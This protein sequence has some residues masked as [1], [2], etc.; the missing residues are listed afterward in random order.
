MTEDIDMA[1]SASR[2]VSRRSPSPGWLTAVCIV[3]A[4]V[5]THRPVAA[6][7]GRPL[8]L[9]D[10]Y[11]IESVGNGALSPDGTWL[12]FVR[13]RI[14]EA[15]NRRHS[16]I[17]LVPTDGSTAPRRLTSPATSAANPR[18]S[19]DGTLLAFSSTRRLPEETRRSTATSGSCRWRQVVA[20]RFRFLV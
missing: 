10:Y 2:I 16:E 3:A 6:Q 1:V 12:A 11:R 19:P 14:I 8:E 7:D 20:K 9:Q 13:S 5:I 15:E 17:W 18:W 4:L